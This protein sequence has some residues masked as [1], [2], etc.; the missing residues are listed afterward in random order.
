MSKNFNIIITAF[1]IW[2]SLYTDPTVELFISGFFILS[3]GLI[4]GANDINLIQ[5]ML[6][7]NQQK[8]WFL[9]T[10][11]VALGFIIFTTVYYLRI[12]GL[13]VFMIVSSYHFGE[14]HLHKRLKMAPMKWLHFTLYGLVIFTYLFSTHVDEVHYLIFNM[15]EFDISIINLDQLAIA[16]TVALIIFWLFTLKFFKTEIFEELFFLLMFYVVFY[17]TELYLAFG[18]YFVVWHAL[19]SIQDQILIEGRKI[20]L[21]SVM[22]YFKQSAIYWLI[23]LVGIFIL[24]EGFDYFGTSLL[25][26]LFAA[27]VAITFPH[28]LLISRLISRLNKK[29]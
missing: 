5:E 7:S 26:V 25:P 22:K 17:N 23:S 13:I 19:P 27:L 12:L 16:L 3:L 15:T 4:H 21:N 20:E 24:A 6:R 11:Y 14:Q 18:L 28:I 1:V 2:I 29:N 10:L 9:I 8:K